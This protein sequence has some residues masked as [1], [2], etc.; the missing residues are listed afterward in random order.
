LTLRLGNCWTT[1]WLRPRSTFVIWT[2]ED[3]T[4]VGLAE[5]VWPTAAID[6]GPAY[7]DRLMVSWLGK[8]DFPAEAERND[9]AWSKTEWPQGTGEYAGVKHATFIF[10]R[11]KLPEARERAK[12]HLVCKFVS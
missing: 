10:P 7:E 12:Q 1:A 3:G 8:G 2:R 6:E 9:Y 4:R 11:D 5:I